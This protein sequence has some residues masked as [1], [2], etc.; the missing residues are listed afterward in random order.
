[1]DLDLTQWILFLT[2]ICLLL[3]IGFF[4]G[5]FLDLYWRAGQIR[6][7]LKKDVII[8]NIRQ[9]DR[10]T[11]LPQLVTPETKAVLFNNNFWALLKDRIY[12]EKIPGLGFSL[13]ST[14]TK[15]YYKQGIPVVFTDCDSVEPLCFN[16]ITP[17]PSAA[18]LGAAQNAWDLNQRAK[19]LSGV[20]MI[21]L[22]LVLACLVGGAAAG[23]SFMNNN[24]LNDMQTKCSAF[25]SQNTTEPTHATNNTMQITQPKK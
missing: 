19:N 25:N 8:V 5:R 17:P 20:Q 6:R 10:T 22:L 16:D 18:E 9:K 3:P 21:M 4:I 2:G 12:V 15:I 24:T 23:L 1:M 11:F 14:N 7:F 13:G